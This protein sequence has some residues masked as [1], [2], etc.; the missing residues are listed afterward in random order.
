MPFFCYLLQSQ[1]K[2]SVCYVGYTKT[3]RRRL[4]QHNGELVAGAWKTHKHRPWIHVCIVS[5]FPN[6]I[7]ALQFEWQWQHAKRS[8]VL[9]AARYAGKSA[10]GGSGVMLSVLAA[11]LATPLWDRLRLTVHFLDGE[12]KAA[13]DRLLLASAAVAAL[14]ATSRLTT[15]DAVDGMHAVTAAA[16]SVRGVCALCGLAD[17]V[18]GPPTGGTLRFN[19]RRAWTCSLCAGEWRAHLYCMVRKAC[20]G[21]AQGA[22]AAV[23]LHGCCGRCGTVQP[24]VDIVRASHLLLGEGD[25]G[26]DKEDEEAGEEEDDDDGNRSSSKQ[27]KRAADHGAA[28]AAGAALL[29]LVTDS[30]GDG[31]EGSDDV[32]D[33]LVISD[34]DDEDD[35]DD[36]DFEVTCCR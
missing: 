8:R 19:S 36:D 3:P 10:R 16:P 2:P 25:E 23:P 30:D 20:E 4:R 7:V 33:V 1:P 24:W 21:H 15:A 11:L 31:D 14:S 9:T 32:G 34:D 22:Q 13:F 35:D 12:H 29:D 5:G 17:V 18:P 6:G 28:A 26:S 27:R